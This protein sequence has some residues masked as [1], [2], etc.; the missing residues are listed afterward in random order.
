M[1]SEEDLERL[2]K[3]Q[4]SRR[5]ADRLNRERQPANLKHKS[6]EEELQEVKEALKKEQEARKKEQEARM[7][8]EKEQM[9]VEKERDKL[10]SMLAKYEG[11]VTPT[12]KRTSGSDGF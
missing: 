9:K 8:A 3:D 6:T 5:L 12:N 10:Q 2:E 1:V 11:P 4:A 7:K